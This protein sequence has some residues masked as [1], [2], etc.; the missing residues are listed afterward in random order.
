MKNKNMMTHKRLT[1]PFDTGHTNYTPNNIDG[2][3]AIGVLDEAG[4]Q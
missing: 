1:D 4:E 2:I 3:D